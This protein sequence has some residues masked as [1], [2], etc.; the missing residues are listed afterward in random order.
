MLIVGPEI[1]AALQ[2]FAKSVVDAIT[3]LQAP[4]APVRLPYVLLQADLPDAAS[5]PDSA[6]LVREKLT[7]AISTLSGST[8]SWLRA[9]GSAL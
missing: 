3:A 9:D 5:Y 7:V 4:G 1:P 6:I 8:W 2:P